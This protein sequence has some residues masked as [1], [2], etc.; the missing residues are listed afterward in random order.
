LS[1]EIKRLQG[2]TFFRSYYEAAIELP[3]KH[4]LAFYDAVVA[5]GLNGEEP[6]LTGLANAM[7]RLAR[8]NL[9]TSRSKSRHKDEPEENQ[10]ATK[11]ETKQQP[12]RKPNSNQSGTNEPP[13]AIQTENSRLLNKKRNKKRNKEMDKEMDKEGE[14]T[15]H[16]P[17]RGEDGGETPEPDPFDAFWELYPRK[18]GGKGEARKAWKK[19]NPG[20][21][22]VEKI[23][24]AVSFAKTSREWLKEGGQYIPHPTTWLNQG[25][26]DDE[27][28][29]GGMDNTNPKPA[30]MGK[31]DPF[32]ESALRAVENV[33]RLNKSQQ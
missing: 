26:W 13:N 5:Y 22:L 19:I 31:N 23:L 15:P 25:R 24:S 16:T 32:L 17:L 11:A 33:Q 7:F 20:K 12:E 1:D 4:R 29:P 28:T 14:K 2:F 27:L 8:P 9:D 21:A 3:E 6:T 30:P 10:T 18:A